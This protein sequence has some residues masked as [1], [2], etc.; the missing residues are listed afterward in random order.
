MKILFIISLQD[1][2]NP[3]KPLNNQQQIQFGVSYIS[4]V[5]KSK[6]YITDIFVLTRK[7][8][9]KFLYNFIM[10]FNPDIIGFTAVATEYKFISKI[11]R[12]IR[13]SFPLIYLLIGGPHVSLNPNE[14]INDVFDAVCIGEGEYPT[15]ELIDQLNM[16]KKPIKIKN[17]WIKNDQKIEKNPTRD[18]IQDLDQLPF[19]DRKIWQKWIKWP[20]T[21]HSILLGRGCPFN[22]TYCSNHGLRKL[23]SGKYVRF[24]SIKNILK[25]LKDLVK[26]FPKIKEVYFEIETIGADLNFAIN[27]CSELQRFNNHLK[28]KLSFGVNLRIIPKIDFEPLFQSLKKAN[29]RFINIGIESG[30]ERIREK[31]LK[32]FYSNDD[33]LKNVKLA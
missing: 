12:Y 24:R 7:T 31:V 30:S 3:F 29:F 16:G 2:L 6:G 9:K 19:P 28:K 21:P 20:N 17:F 23:A 18:F 14:P 10:K 25:E 22:C 32:R 15:L 4:S 8:K 13:K 26:K 1:Y 11:A 5:L 33:I 27:L